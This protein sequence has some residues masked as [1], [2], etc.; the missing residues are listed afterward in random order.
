M[1]LTR[2][3]SF[4][5][6]SHTRQFNARRK[7]HPRLSVYVQ[8][9]SCTA[10]KNTQEQTTK[11][12]SDV[13]LQSDEHTQSQFSSAATF[14]QLTVTADRLLSRH[15]AVMCWET[16]D[17]DFHID[18]SWQ[19][20]STQTPLQN[21]YTL[22]ALLLQQDSICCHTTKPAQE[23]SKE[24]DKVCRWYCRRS[25]FLYWPLIIWVD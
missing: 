21:K 20:P 15:S 18:A 1:S 4:V 14:T 8:I 23:Q 2:P 19:K 5:V 13:M 9:Y 7:Q 25:L 10:P 24:C 12:Q 11:C 17:P 16:L 6:W 3:D 22:T